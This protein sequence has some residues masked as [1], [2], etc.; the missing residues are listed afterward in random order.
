M[1]RWPSLIYL[2]HRDSRAAKLE[3]R[4]KLLAH[5]RSCGCMVCQVRLVLLN[6]PFDPSGSA[7]R[8]GAEGIDLDVLDEA[9]LRDLKHLIN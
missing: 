1:N 6:E 9:D 5:C 7:S 2:A 4:E 3:T 8:A